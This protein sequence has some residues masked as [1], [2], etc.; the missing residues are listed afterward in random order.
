MNKEIPESGLLKRTFSWFA[1][2]GFR[3]IP[4]QHRKEFI[5]EIALTNL[6]RARIFSGIVALLIIPLVY[7]D[8]MNKQKGLWI[9]PGYEYLFYDH[10]ILGVG[11]FAIFVLSLIKKPSGKQEATL[12][13]KAQGVVFFV[14][15][16]LCCC[17][18]S[19]VDQLIHGQITVYVVG[20][21]GLAFA[22]L[23][24]S[25]VFIIVY[26]SAFAY[27]IF[28]INMVQ[29]NPNMVF[30][31]FNNVLVVTVV[32]WALSRVIF[33]MKAQDFMNRKTIEEQKDELGK[34]KDRIEE[35]LHNIL[36]EPI[37]KQLNTVGYSM[38]R[39]NPSTTIIF[40]DFVSF[41]KIAENYDSQ[42]LL[43]TLEKI[44]N[45]FDD[46]IRKY[47][48]EKLKTI[49]DGYMFAGG[50]F[51]EGNQLTECVEA[52]LGIVDYIKNNTEELKR[53]TG[54]EWYIRV[55]IH[56]GPAITGIIGQ[57][58]FI[59]D[60]WGPT[61]NIASRL[62]GSSEPNKINISRTVYD[63]MLN[64]EKY[65]IESRGLLSIKNLQPVQMYFL[66]RK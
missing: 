5:N 51:H 9:N 39:M 52:S 47:G 63:L 62:E 45:E 49:G 20:V 54:F 32:A 31:H 29:K 25:Y 15:M 6:S 44:F 58:R 56:T 4:K 12:W 1:K 2:G 30:G 46:I 43:K 38:P 60:V 11:L 40:T 10:I 48:L 50:L 28:G 34:A 59:Y 55:G 24:R 3:K 18:T 21:F 66:D 36:P 53:Q 17:T 64:R 26:L 7:I 61:V 16:I 37:V 42:N 19:I 27:L 41:S 35:L 8:V 65:L 13:H 33:N 14:Y 22:L 57:W 23:F